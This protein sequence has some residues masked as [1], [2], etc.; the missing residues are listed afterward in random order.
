MCDEYLIENPA[1]EVGLWSDWVE[2]VCGWEGIPIPTNK[3]F[4][5][6]RTNWYSGK[7]PVDSVAELKRMR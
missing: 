3:E 4:A 6:L 1:L 2:V 5:Q 7:A